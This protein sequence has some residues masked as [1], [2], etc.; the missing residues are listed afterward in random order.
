MNNGARHRYS[1]K[2]ELTQTGDPIPA[3]VRKLERVDPSRAPS[4]IV[5][6][7]IVA[8]LA[9]AC[10]PASAT[11]SS[12][13]KRPTD[14]RVS[15]PRYWSPTDGS[16]ILT[17]PPG[18]V[19]VNS[20]NVRGLSGSDK[21]DLTAAGKRWLRS[22]L[23]GE[24]GTVL[25][26]DRSTPGRA[27]A[28][29]FCFEPYIGVF[30]GPAAVEISDAASEDVEWAHIASNY[31]ESPGL[32]TTVGH[33]TI[34]G[35]RG[36]IVSIKSRATNCR[37]AKVTMVQTDAILVVK[38]VEYDIWLHVPAANA[39]RYQEIYRAA[40]RAFHPGL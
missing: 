31:G 24:P 6:A 15:N 35:H 25:A 7:C 8:M 33:I 19:G 30:Q 39:R 37:G 27:V 2:R 3:G 14:H 38:G 9:T 1:L 11:S 5:L 20:D 13:G 18:W 32:P 22:T 36:D 21:L 4:L 34:D 16:A 40:V 26:F 28:R 12:V 23:D 29:R 10:G 17:T